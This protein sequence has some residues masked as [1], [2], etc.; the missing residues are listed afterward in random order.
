MKAKPKRKSTPPLPPHAAA[1]R[2]ARDAAGLSQAAV[3]RQLGVGV[4][5]VSRWE[6]GVSIPR[7]AAMRKLAASLGALTVTYEA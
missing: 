3:A 4:L 2:A 7:D 5:L 1:I 6:R